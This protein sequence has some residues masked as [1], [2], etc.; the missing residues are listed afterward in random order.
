M[1]FSFEPALAFHSRDRA[2]SDHRRPV[3]QGSKID[4]YF[5]L[6]SLKSHDMQVFWHVGEANY[7]KTGFCYD[8]EGG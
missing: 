5:G 1:S 2:L 7:G 4:E 8:D 6:F 3:K